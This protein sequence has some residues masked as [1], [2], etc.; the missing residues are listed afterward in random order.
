M[1]TYFI[2]ADP[3]SD[4][5]IDNPHQIMSVGNGEMWIVDN[6]SNIEPGD[7]LISSNTEG[8]GMKDDGTYEVA[9]I[10]A[11][12]SEPVNWETEYEIING[13][14]H[15]KIA[16][17]YESFII[18]HKAEKLELELEEMKKEIDNIK[19]KLGILYD[20]VNPDVQTQNK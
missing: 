6:G 17:F 18:N 13:V 10:I 11:R 4:H 3:Y 20:V 12:A 19:A 9:Y 15:K 8:H 2:L 5:S 1:G 14:K 7:Y 16:V